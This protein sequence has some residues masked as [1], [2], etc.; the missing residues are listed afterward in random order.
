[1]KKVIGLTSKGRE[2]LQ[3]HIGMAGRTDSMTLDEAFCELVDIITP[4]INNPNPALAQA[5]W[6]YAIG[7]AGTM[8][9][10]STHDHETSDYDEVCLTYDDSDLMIR[11]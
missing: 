6:R 2:K 4:Q 7:V 9:P 3:S 10:Q 5:P 8:Y 11:R 1:M